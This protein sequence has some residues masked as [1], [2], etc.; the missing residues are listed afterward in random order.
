MESGPLQCRAASP[1]GNSGE[2]SCQCNT[3]VDADWV[4]KFSASQ[5]DSLLCHQ[6]KHQSPDAPSLPGAIDGKAR[7]S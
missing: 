7:N 6:G 2:T 4:K 5:R 1:T 3:L